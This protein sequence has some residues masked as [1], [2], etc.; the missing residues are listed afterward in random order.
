LSERPKPKKSGAT[1]PRDDAQTRRDERG[2]H[3][4]IEVGPRGLAVQAEGYRRVRPPFIEIMH[5]QAPRALMIMRVERI[6]R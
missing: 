2:D 4:A 3:F 1:V 6:S 5:A